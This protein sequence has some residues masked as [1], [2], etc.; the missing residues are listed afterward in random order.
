MESS[1]GSTVSTITRDEKAKKVKKE[2]RVK[3]EICDQCGDKG[4]VK[5][6]VLCA[7][8]Q[9]AMRHRYCLDVLPKVGEQPFYVCDRCMEES[10][11][12][13]SDGTDEDSSAQSAPAPNNAANP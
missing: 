13:L 11:E 3:K 10:D 8:C 9:V 12:E 5:C 1:T 2:I 6:L 7:I 4:W